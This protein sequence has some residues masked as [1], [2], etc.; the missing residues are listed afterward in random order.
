MYTRPARAVLLELTGRLRL[1]ESPE[2]ALEELATAV[3]LESFRLFSVALGVQWR[4]GGSLDRSLA[5][6]ARAVRD[7]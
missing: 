3:P 6:V 4:A 5:S 1:G 7:R 2:G